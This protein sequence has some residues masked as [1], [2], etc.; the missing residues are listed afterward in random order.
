MQMMY[1]YEGSGVK[2]REKKIEIQMECR[3]ERVDGKK[4]VEGVRWRERRGRR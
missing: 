4:A 3:C 1:R 2:D